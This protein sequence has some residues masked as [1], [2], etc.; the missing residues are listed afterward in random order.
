MADRTP[1]TLC[2]SRQ[3]EP[4]VPNTISA[5]ISKFAS[6]E[7]IEAFREDPFSLHSL[8]LLVRALPLYLMEDTTPPE[9]RAKLRL[10]NMS[11]VAGYA[12]GLGQNTS[13]AL[14]GDDVP[15][16]KIKSEM[17]GNA[18]ALAGWSLKA[19]YMFREVAMG[20]AGFRA[21][22]AEADLDSLLSDGEAASNVSESASKVAQKAYFSKFSETPALKKLWEQAAQDL[23]KTADGFA[24][25]R[26]RFW[27]LVNSD[28]SAEAVFVRG[29]LKEAQYEIQAGS[30]APLLKMK[31]WDS[32]ASRELT[33]RRLSI[34]HDDPKSLSPDKTLD[35]SNLGFL[36]HRD[37]SFKGTR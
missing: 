37:N 8:G 5:Q 14:A 10:H 11:L 29:M 22:L 15:F 36:T 1:G 12:A 4:R 30:N 35:A 24:K 34:D 18:L 21:W 17:P 7:E 20:S 6:Q 31:D 27:Q 3:C 16:S 9:E 13:M 26:R 33:D 25:A 19:L 28:T 32:R 2:S 23:P